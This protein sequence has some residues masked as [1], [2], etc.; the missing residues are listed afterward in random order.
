MRG[1]K[2]TLCL[3]LGLSAATPVVN[4]QS[5][6]SLER[7]EL[8]QRFWTA[9]QGSNQMLT[10][11]D[12]E[13]YICATNMS[14]EMMIALFKEAGEDYGKYKVLRRKWAQQRFDSGL[15]QYAYIHAI[16][17]MATDP[18]YNRDGR[19]AFKVSERDYFDKVQDMESKTLKKWLDQRL[20]IVKARDIFGAEL[21]KA[22]YPH[23][24]DISNTDLYF[25]WYEIQKQRIKEEIRMREVQKFEYIS[26]LGYKREYFV[27]PTDLFDFK[28]EVEDII[29]NQ[30]TNQRITPNKL[31]KVLEGDPRV[32]VLLKNVELLGPDTT[33]LSDLKEQ[34]PEVFAEYSEKIEDEALTKIESEIEIDINRYESISEKLIQK[35]GDADKLEELSDDMKKSFLLGSGDYNHFMM[36]KL[37]TMAALRI[38][39]GENFAGKS[40][41]AMELKKR[42]I[43]QLKEVA[44]SV[45][46]SVIDNP[47]IAGSSRLEDHFIK[48]LNDTEGQEQLK[49]QISGD[50][51]LREYRIMANWVVKFQFKKASLSVIPM[52]K[53]DVYN[54]R[55]WEG[56][57]RIDTYLK[58]L[59]FEQDLDKFRRE[60]MRH[61]GPYMVI[62]NGDR[63]LT[64]DEAWDFVMEKFPKARTR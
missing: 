46:K 52:A 53:T 33:K 42:H 64:S 57:K 55:E 20:G 7:R 36:S 54:A 56:Q 32:S 60:T 13:D 8:V 59:Y 62:N 15:R 58:G 39:Q 26:A 22:G 44:S 35:Y 10:N 24:K 25:E 6:A 3:L 40:A 14:D 23:S 37:Y 17:K 50:E 51:Y 47:E 21:K 12:V 4:A 48:A 28:K 30:I 29:S 16:Q 9:F 45:A 19:K 2:L 41:E 27:R 61:R 63:R 5:A 43:Q 31:A 1:L 38:R 49:D 18:L 34:A 11:M